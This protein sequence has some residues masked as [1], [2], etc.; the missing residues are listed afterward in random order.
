MTGVA[1]EEETVFAGEFA[2]RPTRGAALLRLHVRAAV[3]AREVRFYDTA[4]QPFKMAALV[5][6]AEDG[7]RTMLAVAYE[8]RLYGS[9]Q[10]LGGYAIG[11][12]QGYEAASDE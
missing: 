11:W 7:M 2:M 10:L 6:L 3:E 8:H 1:Q 12:F 5:E 9:K 4:Q